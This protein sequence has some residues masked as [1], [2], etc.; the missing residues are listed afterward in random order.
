MLV[1]SCVE[2]F[3]N[4]KIC[5]EQPQE[6]ISSVAHGIAIT[7]YTSKI[8]FTSLHSFRLGFFKTFYFKC[9]NCSIRINTKQ[10]FAHVTT[11]NRSN[12]MEHLLKLINELDG[13]SL[14]LSTLQKSY[15][16]PPPHQCW[17]FISTTSQKF[18]HTCN[19]FFLHSCK[20]NTKT[21]LL[22]SSFPHRLH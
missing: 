18:G 1:H 14:I 5:Q 20:A 3:K 13:L 9:D 22:Y 21:T 17:R 8:T 2:N 16:H 6:C 12:Q 15:R 11:P 7:I 4:P 10:D 19:F